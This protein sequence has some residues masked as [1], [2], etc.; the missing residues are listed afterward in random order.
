MRV[1]IESLREVPILSHAARKADIHRKTLEYWMKCSE[2]GNV[3][4]DIEWQGVM[5]RFHERCQTAIEEAE[6]RVLA[7]AWDFT[8]GRIIYKTDKNGNRVQWG[9]RGPYRKEHGK[10]LRFLLEWWRPEIYGKRRKV[11]VPHKGGVVVLG[12]TTKK[13]ANC[14][15]ASIKAR[16]WKAGSRMIREAKA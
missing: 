3:G 5:W 15:A 7:A 13:A 12:A 2:A 4:Y 6:D 1:V 11:D 9:F 16:K 10:M 8:M 14:S